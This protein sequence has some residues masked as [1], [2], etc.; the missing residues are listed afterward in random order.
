MTGCNNSTINNNNDTPP[1][2]QGNTQDPKSNDDE[3][4]YEIKDYYPFEDNKKY[5]YEGNGNEYASYNTFVDYLKDNTMQLRVD[6]G[7]SQIIKVIQNKNGQLQVIESRG[8]V[9]YRENLTSKEGT[10]NEILLKEPLIK[11]TS[12]TLPDGKKRYISNTDVEVTTPLGTY[13][14]IEVTTEGKDD[15]N[16][17]YYALNI[18]LVKTVYSS[19][20]TTVTSSLSKIENDSKFVQN[21][22]FYYPNIAEDKMYFAYKNISFKTN[23]ITKSKFEKS[24]K[25]S[26]GNN[27]EVLL[28]PDV[29]INSLYLN[30]DNIVYVDFSK[31]FTTQM[32]AGSGYELMILQCITNTL[33]E[34]YGVNKVYITVENKPY[35]SGHIL[36]EKGETFSV[37][38]K[39]S[40]EYK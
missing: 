8:E 9:Y 26:L 10:T 1:K 23:D 35:S 33:G 25:E 28:G 7:G 2:E 13:K 19:N 15:K 40:V 32:N 12:W 30:K 21:I 5:V 11:G 20:E 4:T 17:D 37:N 18:G 36:M 3:V 24:F 34:Y 31:E 6:N 14:T 39:N 29:K 22:K 27:M 16:I 38:T